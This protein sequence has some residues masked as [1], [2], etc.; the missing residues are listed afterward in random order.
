MTLTALKVFFARIQLSHLFSVLLISTTLQGC[1]GGGGSST[2]SVGAATSS[3]SSISPSAALL[4]ENVEITVTGQNLPGTSTLEI[5]GMT[6]QLPL[7]GL[8][9]NSF[10][11]RCLASTVGVKSIRVVTAVGGNLIDDSKTITISAPPN[12]VSTRSATAMVGPSSLF[13]GT[14]ASF[15]SLSGANLPANVKI[16]APNCLATEISVASGTGFS[17]T[18]TIATGS[19]TFTVKNN[20]VNELPLDKVIGQITLPIRTSSNLISGRFIKFKGD[21]TELTPASIIGWECTLDITTGKLWEVRFDLTFTGGG[22]NRQGGSELSYQVSKAQAFITAKKCGSSIWRRPLASDL[23]QIRTKVVSDL[24]DQVSN[25]A[26]EFTLGMGLSGWF[27]FTAPPFGAGS[28]ANPVCNLQPDGGGVWY[29]S[30]LP[31]AVLITQCQAS[32]PFAT[33]LVSD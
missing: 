13:L 12:Q 14:L 33:V 29:R 9:A 2:G 4:G 11:V 24:N 21:G 18:P 26:T 16:S 20:S 1:G 8:A 32:G 30:T 7:G 17:C 31:N 19:I 25:P 22:L 23:E 3:V 6:C 15:T 27:I 10:S 28:A 5:P